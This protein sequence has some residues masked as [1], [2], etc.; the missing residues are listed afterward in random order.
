MLNPKLISD[1][2]AE[3]SSFWVAIISQSRHTS[4]ATQVIASTCIM[5]SL[6]TSNAALYAT[7][8]ISTLT[9]AA[10]IQRH[11]SST[12]PKSPSTVST[13]RWLKQRLDGLF[14][15]IGDGR[16]PPKPLCNA[17][18]AR[19]QE[20]RR[21]TARG[22]TSASVL[23][24]ELDVAYDMQIRTNSEIQAQNQ[25]LARTEQIVAEVCEDVIENRRN[26]GMN[27]VVI[28]VQG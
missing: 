28:N 10:L 7:T 9:L 8:A 12:A 13:R 23:M 19:S 4:S 20:Q 15:L 21:T 27:R 2:G 11:S 24:A 17:V 16:V 18:V 14:S 26:I 6:P 5:L 1:C 3:F 22:A 25:R